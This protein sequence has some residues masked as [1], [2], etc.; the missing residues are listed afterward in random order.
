MH[1]SNSSPQI[2]VVITCFTLGACQIADM[3]G[4]KK[5]SASK[6]APANASSSDSA[7]PAQ[8]AS[9]SAKPAQAR[10]TRT[11]GRVL[12]SPAEFD[13]YQALVKEHAVL[14]LLAQLSE[15]RIRL[16]IDP[17]EAA[18]E[19]R[20]LAPQLKAVEEFAAECGPYRDLFIMNLRPWQEPRVACDTATSAKTATEKLATL[21]AKR[22]VKKQA[23]TVLATIDSLGN[24]Y[25]SSEQQLRTLLS[26]DPTAER[27]RVTTAVAPLAA[28]MGNKLDVSEEIPNIGELRKA[29]LAKGLAATQTHIFSRT[30]NAAIGKAAK[31]TLSK[32]K[33]SPKVAKVLSKT[34]DWAIHK[35]PSGVPSYRGQAI[36]A[37]AKFK[38]DS[39][40][41]LYD[42]EAQQSYSGGRWQSSVNVTITNGFRIMKCK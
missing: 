33:P 4:S 40:C 18:A 36:Q 2:L 25:A 16:S 41:R 34:N 6:P 29:A 28:L 7:A 22:Y 19:I 1:L 5:T 15:E 26:A 23:T 39:F 20:G 11:D 12:A 21:A 14:E 3:V 38:G 42:M 30:A 27:L 9:S 35:K 24:G 13:A 10:S 31:A 32:R 37:I 17:A 8:A